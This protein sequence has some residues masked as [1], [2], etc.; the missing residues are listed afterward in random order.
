MQEPL[1]LCLISLPMTTMFTNTRNARLK[2][3]HTA[4]QQMPISTN[5]TE[6]ML[7]L[8][9]DLSLSERPREMIFIGREWV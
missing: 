1:P 4:T 8:G 6:R 5:D 3:A 2:A 9:S 7:R